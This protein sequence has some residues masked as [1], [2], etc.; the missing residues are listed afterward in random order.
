MTTLSG[1]ASQAFAEAMVIQNA[2]ISRSERDI[3]SLIGQPNYGG[4]SPYFTAQRMVSGVMAGYK[5][6]VGKTF[7]GLGVISMVRPS[8]GTVL[9]LTTGDNDVGSSSAVAMTNNL[10][11]LV[12]TELLGSGDVFKRSFYF[13]LDGAQNKY[14]GGTWSASG[15]GVNTI[16]I[17]GFEINTPNY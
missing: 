11:F 16:N 15:S 14:L 8:A 2:I 6:A 1:L 12:A 9:Y 7:V 3:I 5:P 4:P 17:I 10:E 13:T